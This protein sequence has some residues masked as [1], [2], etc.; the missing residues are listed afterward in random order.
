MIYRMIV[1]P[2]L[3][4]WAVLIFFY[5]PC[6]SA[7]M[8]FYWNSA[9]S[10]SQEYDDNINLTENNTEDDFI[11]LIT[12]SIGFG[13]R[14]EDF[15]ASIDLS[16]GFSFYK[17]QKDNNSF[18]SNINL[19]NFK[20]FPLSENL[21]LDLDGSFNISEDP[22]EIDELVASDRVGRN[23][24]I[25]NRSSAR[26]TYQF[27]EEEL[28][29]GG[30]GNTFLENSDPDVEDS[31]EH[32]P[33]LGLSYWFDLHHGFTAT[34]S[35]AKAAFD[36]SSDYDEYTASTSYIWRFIESTSAIVAYSV[37]SRDFDGVEEQDYRFQNMTLGFSHQFSDSLLASANA[38]M[39]RQDIDLADD[40]TGLSWSVTIS[41]DYEDILVSANAGYYQQ[42]PDDFRIDREFSGSLSLSKQYD[43]GSISVTGRRSFQEQFFEA[44]NLGFT[45]EESLSATYSIQPI[46]DLGIDITGLFRKNEYVE[47]IFPRTDKTWQ[48][49]TTA[50]YR[51]F[52]WLTASFSFSHRERDSNVIDNSYKGNRFFLSF[53]Y[54]YEGKPIEF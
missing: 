44:E 5:P 12:E 39:Y 20:D 50:S 40:D 21:I 54:P 23:R 31:L 18:R 37:V 33:F 4:L 36:V 28:I 10:L 24:Y 43:Y 14:S 13:V 49:G 48:I 53:S 7:Q 45:M 22:V 35:Y 29:Y 3:L 32:K 51:I 34:S 27:G 52:E 17:E 16:L 30:Y 1:L 41:K 8:E 6:V 47:L 25:R 46:E 9:L 2:V 26:I 38:G 15:D 19:S 11:T 42:N